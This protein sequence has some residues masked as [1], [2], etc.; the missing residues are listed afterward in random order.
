MTEFVVHNY[1]VIIVSSNCD[2]GLF[3]NWNQNNR[4]ERANVYR[5]NCVGTSQFLPGKLNTVSTYKLDIF[6]K[7]R[8]K[9]TFRPIKIF[10]GPE[11]VISHNLPTNSHVPWKAN[12]RTNVARVWELVT[13]PSLQDGVVK[14]VKAWDRP[15]SSV[16]YKELYETHWIICFNDATWRGEPT[17]QESYRYLINVLLLGFSFHFNF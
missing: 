11:T 15:W 1:L 13:S 6:H 4:K 12:S 16:K 7:H 3:L 5:S 2:E 8:T 17:I 14:R 10:F 9:L